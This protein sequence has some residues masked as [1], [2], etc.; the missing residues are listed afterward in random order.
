MIYERT[1]TGEKHYRCSF[2]IKMFAQNQDLKKHERTHTGEKTY[3]CS[4]CDKKFEGNQNIKMH[5]R[6]HTS[7]KPFECLYCDKT[8][9]RKNIMKKHERT[10]T[11]EKP[12]IC[13]QCISGTFRSL[14]GSTWNQSDQNLHKDNGLTPL[15][16]AS[17][18][19]KYEVCKILVKAWRKED[20]TN[21]IFVI[22]TSHKKAKKYNW[23]NVWSLLDLNPA[24]S[25][26]FLSKSLGLTLVKNI[27][28]VL[29]LRQNVCTKSRF[30]ETWKNIYR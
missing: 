9:A 27:M 2:C 25:S 16:M 21:V 1:H 26:F 4:Y 20:F 28:D 15:H 19:G 14:Q 12:Y 8:F 3:A 10:F 24:L 13:L 29:F 22:L 18:K 7:K 23:K 17:G 30:E 5:E 6:I 11:D